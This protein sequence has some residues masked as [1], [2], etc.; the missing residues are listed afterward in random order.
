[1]IVGAGPTGLTLANALAAYGVPFTI[2]DPKKG[3][4]SDSKAVALNMMSQYGL[5]LIGL[6]GK[7]GSANCRVRRININWRGKRLMGVDFSKLDPSLSSFITQPQS[8]TEQE[9]IVALAEQG[10]TVAWGMKVI[11]ITDQET[12]VHAVFEDEAS[13]RTTRRFSYIVGCDGK[14]SYVREHMD[15]QFTGYDYPMHFVLGDFALN[16]D[17]PEDQA[18]YFVFDE[19]FFILVPVE[20]GLWRVV[21]KHDGPVS[22]NTAIGANEITD[23]VSSYMGS[24]FFNGEPRWISRAPFYMRICDRIKQGRL[25]LAGDAAHLFSPIGGTGMNTGIQDALNIAWKLAYCFHGY[26]SDELLDSYASERLS[27][28]HMNAL[29]TDQSTRLIS[30]I[31]RDPEKVA[32]MLPLMKNREVFRKVFPRLYAGLGFSYVGLFS[33]GCGISLPGTIRAGEILFV[34]NKLCDVLG[35]NLAAKKLPSLLIIACFENSIESVVLERLTNLQ[36]DY[37]EI[38][39]TVVS[40]PS[41]KMSEISCLYPTLRILNNIDALLSSGGVNPGSLLLILPDG[42]VGY[43]GELKQ[44]SALCEVLQSRYLP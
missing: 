41:E 3:P 37:G 16:W 33:D 34:L 28:I 18:Y 11:A 4:S 10:H 5:D 20:T 35:L 31:D 39:N 8:K 6:F 9:L 14:H 22:K 42:V 24:N 27:V 12:E 32:Q 38:L 25:L 36:N 17:G 15:V 44:V 26:A 7:L 40:I 21:V 23:I 1:L 13:I 43:S 30:R 29:A 2:V 19:T